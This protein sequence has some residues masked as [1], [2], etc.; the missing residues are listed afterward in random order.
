VKAALSSP[1]LAMRLPIGAI[2]VPLLFATVPNE[3]ALAGSYS[4]GQHALHLREASMAAFVQ[5]GPHKRL[6]RGGNRAVL[7]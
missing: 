1:K 5:G 4:L 2:T 3:A 7:R 6:R